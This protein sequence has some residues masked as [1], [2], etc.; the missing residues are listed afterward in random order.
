[1]ASSI[2]P[3]CSKFNMKKYK[4]S[5]LSQKHHA[6]ARGVEWQLTFEEWFSWWESTGKLHLRGRNFGEYCMCRKG[7]TG[8]YSL[9]NIYCATVSQNVRDSHTNNKIPYTKS[10]LGKT[11]SEETK[12]K[13]SKSSKTI[14]S[15][16]EID[17]RLSILKKYGFPKRGSITKSSKELG[18]SHTQLNRFVEKYF[19]PII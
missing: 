17:Y 12:A 19:N 2:L 14:L 5:Y 16:D 9:E 8:P 1:M 13:M 3:G 15:S 18:I 10:F 11:H 6:I 4:T 7:D